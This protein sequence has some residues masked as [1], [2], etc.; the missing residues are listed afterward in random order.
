[1]HIIQRTRTKKT[2]CW[3]HTKCTRKLLSVSLK[4]SVKCRS[5]PLKDR[6]FDFTNEFKHSELSHFTLQTKKQIIFLWDCFYLKVKSQNGGL[7][8]GQ[9]GMFQSRSQ[10]LSSM[11]R[12]DERC[13]E[14]GWLCFS[15][16][17]KMKANRRGQNTAAAQPWWFQILILFSKQFFA[18][19]LRFKLSQK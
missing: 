14:R 16:H 13:W 3:C 8:A 1:M 2:F 7:P 18:D 6:C 12:W 10:G 4:A 11:G 15:C 17:P 5:E 19:P 9:L